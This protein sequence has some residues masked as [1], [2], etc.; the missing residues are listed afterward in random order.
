VF[1]KV[2]AAEKIVC[3]RGVIQELAI[4]KG[5][6]AQLVSD[7]SGTEATCKQAKFPAMHTFICT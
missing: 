2:A 4:V 5:I 1:Y 3:E 6:F 7:R